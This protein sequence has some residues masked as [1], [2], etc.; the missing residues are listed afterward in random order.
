M[1]RIG[2]LTFHRVTNYGAVLQAYALKQ[3][4][5]DLG[6]ETHIINYKNPNIEEYTTPVRR[7]WNSSRSARDMST[8]LGRPD[9][10]GPVF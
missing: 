2:I 1:K 10:K 4:C 6:Y 7:Y 3:V 8:C 9:K 5:D